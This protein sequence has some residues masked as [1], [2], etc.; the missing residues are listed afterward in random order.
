MATDSPQAGRS[1]GYFFRYRCSPLETTFRPD[2]PP[3]GEP[4]PGRFWL[5][6][7]LPADPR[8]L[9]VGSSLTLRQSEPSRA[10][11]GAGESVSLSL[12]R[13]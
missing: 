3:A 2:R 13:G 4:S 5:S 10:K 11:D 6:G 9:R 8:E 7:R 1:A 12:R